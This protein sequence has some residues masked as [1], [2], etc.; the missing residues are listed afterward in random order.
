MS[1]AVFAAVLA[2]A[3]MHAG[4]NAMV[5][6]RLEPIL[7]MALIT[8]AAGVIAL[9]ALAWFGLP[10]FEAWPW[11]LGSIL[12]HLGYYV[13]L[14]EAYR[15]ADMS[16]VYPIARGS[17]PLL[18][19]LVS[20][21]ILRE[22][23]APLAGL[24]ILLLCAG[25]G[26]IA[27]SRGKGQRLRPQ[28][29]AYAGLTALLICGYTLVDGIGARVAENPH[30][31]SAALFVVDGIPL[32]LFVL[33]RRGRAVLEPMRRV[34]V[35]GMIGGLLSLGSYWIAI[36]A[37]TVAPIP[38]VAATRETSVLFAVL[39]CVTIL[40]E[41]LPATRATAA[42]LVVVGVAAMRLA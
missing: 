38:L 12:L 7:T 19:M 17:A 23:V 5:K 24:G 3:C 37:M 33:W 14:T 22:A 31:Y 42:L 16:Q 41:P 29:L 20:V 4:W 2:G 10:R 25:V 11:L 8:A 9:P 34:L 26:L 15:H 39:I 6:L 30:A 13:A 27:L 21:V 1:P 40:K 18:T 35:P 28:A 36:W 32:L